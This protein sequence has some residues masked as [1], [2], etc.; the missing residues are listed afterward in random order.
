MS[1]CVVRRECIT[2]L[3]DMHWKPYLLV[4]IYVY[5]CIYLNRSLLD[6]GVTPTLLMTSI[7]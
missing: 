6:V 5:S 2:G 4:V 3:L 1:F 7:E